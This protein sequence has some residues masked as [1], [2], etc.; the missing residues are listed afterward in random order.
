MPFLYSSKKQG[1]FIDFYLF[2][3]SIEQI[4]PYEQH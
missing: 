2:F 4:A 3:R 1:V